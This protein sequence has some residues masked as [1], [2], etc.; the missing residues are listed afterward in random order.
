MSRLPVF[1]PT[2]ADEQARVIADAVINR[3][4][5]YGNSTC[6]L[7]TAVGFFKL[8]ASQS[9]GKCTPCRIGLA[10]LAD[11]LE[12]ILRGEHV[13]GIVDQ[14]IMVC[15]TLYKSADC[16]IGFQAGRVGLA[17]AD[18]IKEDAE[19]HLA[20][21][22]CTQPFTAVPCVKECP[23]H[24][25]IP[26]YI[27]CLRD[28]RPADAVRVIRNDNPFPSAC[29]F[30]CEHP[31]EHTCRR[32]MIDAPVN[33]RGMKQHAVLTAG[34]VDAPEKAPAT[35]KKVAIIGGGPSGLTAAYY[36]ALMGHD[37][38][39]YEQNAHLGGMMY[40]GI[41]RYRLPEENLQYDIDAILSLGIDVK[42]GVKVGVGVQWEELVE[43]YDAVYVAI[44]AHHFKDLGIEYA[45]REGVM[46]AVQF[47]HRV[48]DGR[49]DDVAGKDVVV[50]GGGN[51][52][53]DATRTAKR[54]GAASVRCIY[55]R[56][57]EDM[58][59]L[60][61]EVE[62]AIAEGC[63]MVEL[64]SPVRID[65]GTDHEIAFVGQPQMPSFYRGG[66]PAPKAT[67]AGEQVFEC[68][69]LVEAIGQVIEYEYFAEKGL[70]QN[71]GRF[72]SDGHGLAKGFDNVFVG[73]D[74]QTGPSTVIRAIAAGKA[75]A[76][77]IDAYLGYGH[78]VFDDVHIPR[79]V[80]DSKLA[81]GRVNIHERPADERGA[82]FDGVE[83]PLR[84]E[85][86][87]QECGR[88]LRCDHFGMGPLRGGR[89]DKW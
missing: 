83:I 88:C 48:A 43:G 15:D 34:A 79:S 84:D 25:D 30:V 64:M 38:T 3:V 24:V 7:E 35:G 32:G 78:D 8:C 6:P 76:A 36:L 72:V 50:V 42:L 67:E 33:I 44:G 29:A 74:C 37:I 80:F 21:G 57:I 69:I 70:E 1:A 56:R 60:P 66:R 63:E 10:R 81:C 12:S 28:G 86:A 61:E 26:G 9:C 52:A 58:T 31:C 14:V 54:L 22:V 87:A 55:R 49:P 18:L 17:F 53:M 23:S 16:A 46:S 82:D 11:G 4:S 5:V 2:K 51:V 40:Y 59:A 89:P 39:V 85:E 75:V 41:P 27:A 71:R 62:A 47:L 19:S 77:N 65:K 68:D 73:G 45:T 13:E 20:K